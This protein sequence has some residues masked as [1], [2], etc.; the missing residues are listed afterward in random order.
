MGTS[1]VGRLIRAALNGAAIHQ[2]KL[3]AAPELSGQQGVH[4]NT[5]AGL[6]ENL[7]AEPFLWRLG[8]FEPAARQPPWN[9]ATIRVL[10]HQNPA[11]AVLDQRHRADHERGIQNAEEHAAHPSRKRHVTPEAQ[12]EAAATR[13]SVWG[14]SIDRYYR[15]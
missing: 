3:A 15:K 14:H 8:V 1:L 13:T 12:E 10:H 5:Q 4:P 6:L 11:L 9:F 7:A 2:V